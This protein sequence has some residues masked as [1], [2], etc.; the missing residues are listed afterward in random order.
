MTAAVSVSG[1][2]DRPAESG[3]GAT[4]TTSET[5]LV[6][7]LNLKLELE[8]GGGKRDFSVENK[9]KLLTKV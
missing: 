4:G 2:K 9:R 5:S 1:V 3:L 7:W 8:P 6:K